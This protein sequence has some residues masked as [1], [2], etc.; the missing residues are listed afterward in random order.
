MLVT[1]TQK[2]V[3]KVVT[4][5]ETVKEYTITLTEEEAKVL[6]GLVGSIKYDSR[7]SGRITSKLYYKLL[8][9]LPFEVDD[10]KYFTGD[11]EAQDYD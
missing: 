10:M 1:E 9:Y 8:E 7:K 3:D 11:L 2:I 4:V 6:K 5:K